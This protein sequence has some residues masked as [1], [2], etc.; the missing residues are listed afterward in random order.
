MSLY[1][2]MVSVTS[3]WQKKSYLLK[4]GYN[5]KNRKQNVIYGNVFSTIIGFF[6]ASLMIASP[7]RLD[8]LLLFSLLISQKIF[9]QPNTSAR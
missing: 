6:N 5:T 9:L 4:N 1:P 3:S 2:L 8:F 7:L